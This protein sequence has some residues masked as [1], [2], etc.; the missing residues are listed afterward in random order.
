M[1]N[2]GNFRF[3]G[4]K[5]DLERRITQWGKDLDL[6]VSWLRQ[7]ISSSVLTTM[8]SRSKNIEG[9]PSFVLKGGTSMV[10]RFGTHAR[11][12]KDF[13]AA[14]RG[15]SRDI[16]NSL[17]ATL[18]DPLWQF[19]A[20]FKERDSFRGDRLQVVV[21]RYQIAIKYLG[22]PFNT[23]NMEVTLQPEVVS[24]T[25]NAVL[26]LS[27]VRLPL[28]TN[29]EILAIER[30]IAEKWH[31]CTEPDQDGVPNDRVTDIYDLHLLIRAFETVGPTSELLLI[32]EEVF[33]ARNIHDW[34]AE[35]SSRAGW[36]EV[37]ANLRR[38]LPLEALEI[39][40][41]LVDAINELNQR[42]FRQG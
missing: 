15:F 20:T 9:H 21:Y 25:V 42:L 14:Y 39:P 18:A 32:C 11:A 2:T 28:P 37:W 6:P 19:E 7:Y 1:T 17:S 3:P 16:S 23:I 8:L 5:S 4:S 22:D 38:D 12:T 29:M 31:A 40:T 41:D 24:E 10:M 36:Q 13:D 35:I 33:L 30:Q 26:D 34:P 27:P